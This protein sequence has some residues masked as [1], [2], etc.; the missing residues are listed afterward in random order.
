MRPLPESAS[1]G[2]RLGTETSPYLLQH[3]DNPV[4]WQPWGEAAFDAARR[5]GRPVLLSVGYAACHW[6]HVMAHECF[7]D[8]AIAGLMN[9]LFVNIKVDREERPEIDAIYQQALALLGQHGGWPLTMFLTAEREPF[10]GGTYFPPQAKFGRPGFPEVLRRIAEVHAGEPAAVAKNA[11]AIL[12]ALRRPARRHDGLELDLAG[13]DRLA[14]ALAREVDPQ[15]GGIGGAPKFPQPYAFQLLWRSYLRRGLEAPRR[16]VETTLKQMCQGG[17]YDHLGGGFARYSTDEQWLVPHFEK[18]LYDNAQM[19]DLLTLVWQST[20]EPL[21]AIR[22]AETIA[23]LEREML[24]PEGAFAAAL[25]ADSEGEEGKYY[26]WPEAEI[27]RLLA[28]G[29]PRFK[30]VY[31]VSAEGNW[32]QTNILNRSS[33]LALLSPEEE[34]A[35]SAQ[36]AILLAARNARPRPGWDDKVLADWNGLAIGAVARAGAAFRRADWLALAQRAFSAVLGLAQRDGRLG[37]SAR[38]GQR[39]T[40]AILEDYSTLIDAAISLYEITGDKDFLNHA[41]SWTAVVLEHY[42]EAEQGGFCMTADDA[43]PLIVRPRS[44][45][46]NAV[47]SGNG[48]MVAALAKLALLTGEARHRERAEAILRAFAGDLAANPLAAPTLLNAAELLIRPVQVAILGRRGEAGT[49]AL[50]AAALSAPVPCRVLQVAEPGQ[51]LPAGHPAA[52]KTARPGQATA[53]VCVG[54]VCSLPV[55]QPAALTA[56]LTARD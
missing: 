8:P 50:L 31:D 55:S 44:C 18:M 38:Q 36:R 46:D 33:H 49:D 56:A 29:A 10:W 28:A 3:R 45:H 11:D 42:W 24:T 26:V 2:N 16:A 35:L 1:L 27:D 20:A 14:L 43:E 22:V 9:E 48:G 41:R 19:I 6:C 17:I 54:P 4:H 7:E 12:S 23:W 51:P 52:G 37:H 32:E 40:T 25:D 13:L 53:Y 5:S 21:F 30:Q 34:S 15:L 39:L 47:P